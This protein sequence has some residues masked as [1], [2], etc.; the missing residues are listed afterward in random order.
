M[1]ITGD[2]Q[3]VAEVYQSTLRIINWYTRDMTD[4][5]SILSFFN[6]KSSRT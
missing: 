3:S 6:P 4:S 1:F 5:F 2:A